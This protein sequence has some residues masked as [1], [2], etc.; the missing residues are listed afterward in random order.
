MSKSI[1][2]RFVLV[3]QYHPNNNTNGRKVSIKNENE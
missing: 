1:R 2:G 3:V